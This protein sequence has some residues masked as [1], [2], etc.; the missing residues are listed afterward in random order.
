MTIQRLIPLLTLIPALALA[1]EQPPQ[2]TTP[3]DVQPLVKID[4]FTITNLHYSVFAAQQGRPIPQ[5][6]DQQ[7]RLLN[8]LANT[9]MVAHS[10]RGQELATT[11]EV[12][13]ALEVTQ[14]RIIAR[15][16]IGDMME[17]DPVSDAEIQAAYD[18][19]YGKGDHREYKARHI[20]VKTENEAKTIIAELDKS[21]DFAKLAREKSTGPS[22][23]M[24]GDLG[25]FSPDSMV[26]PFAEAVARLKD[27][28]YSKKPVKTRFGWHVILREKSRTLPQPK[29]EDVKDELIKQ[30]R[31]A[32]LTE[33]IRGLRDK[34]HIEVVGSGQKKKA[35]DTKKP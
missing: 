16:V 28:E 34:M 8:E 1:Q 4:D 25:W 9:F 31:A 11:D 35:S 12:K 26:K 10:P 24:G 32:R 7:I 29:L 20:L 27:G 6:R 19:E 2:S 23:H 15:A 13:V 21:A 30:I 33:Y 18:K 14:A 5:D 17:T 3:T 22:A